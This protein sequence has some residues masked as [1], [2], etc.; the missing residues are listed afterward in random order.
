MMSYKNSD[1]REFFE[2]PRF[3]QHFFRCHE[4]F[5]FFDII[6]QHC[7]LVVMYFAWLLF[8]HW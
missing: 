2:F 6:I 7:S 5:T 3:N 8:Y 4:F 1:I